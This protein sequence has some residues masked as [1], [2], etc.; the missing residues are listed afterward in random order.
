MTH[1]DR[2]LMPG[3]VKWAVR[4]QNGRRR[5]ISFSYQLLILKKE[6][7]RPGSGGKFNVNADSVRVCVIVWLSLETND[8]L[9]F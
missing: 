9:I 3:T 6:Q 5:V 7:R 4:D 8:L 1:N 2:F